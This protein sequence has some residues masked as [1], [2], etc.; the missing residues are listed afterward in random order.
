MPRWQPFFQQLSPKRLHSFLHTCEQSPRR[1]AHSRAQLGPHT[2][3][4]IVDMQPTADHWTGLRSMQSYTMR[5][6]QG[7]HDPCPDVNIVWL[8]HTYHRSVYILP[9]AVRWVIAGPVAPMPPDSCRPQYCPLG[10]WRSA[11]SITLQQVADAGSQT[12]AMHTSAPNA[13][14]HTP[15]QSVAGRSV[16]L[17]VRG[18][19]LKCHHRHHP[20]RRERGQ[21]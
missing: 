14:G 15:L 20:H 4:P 3:W 7:G 19:P 13:N 17:G 11:G 21:R 1:V 8:T 6:L 10:A 16:R 18:P 5:P 2:T 12:A 9:A